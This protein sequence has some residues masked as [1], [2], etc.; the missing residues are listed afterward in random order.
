MSI[1]RVKDEERNMALTQHLQVAGR[2]DVG[3]KRPIN[4]DT[5]RTQIPNTNARSTHALFV[6]ADGVGGNLPRG[7]AASRAAVDT[8]IDSF[9]QQSDTTTPLS[10]VE[11]AVQVA[12]LAVQ[13]QAALEGVDRIGTTLAGLSLTP[14]GMA[15]VFNVGDSRVYRIRDEKIELLSHD[16]ITRS[17]PGVVAD[18]FQQKRSTRISSY[19]GQPDTLQPIFSRREVRLND[20]YIICTDG[21]WSKVSDDELKSILITEGTVDDAADRI[22]HL[23]HERG[24]PDNLTLVITHIGERLIAPVRRSLLPLLLLCVLLALL[25]AGGVYAAQNGVFA[26]PAP[27]EVAVILPTVTQTDT[28]EPISTDTA[29]PPTRTR[30]ASSTPSLTVTPSLTTMPPTATATALP[31]TLTSTPTDLPSSTPTVIPTAVVPTVTLDQTAF[32]NTPT[33]SAT[34]VSQ[35]ATITGAV[36]LPALDDPMSLP[37][38]LQIYSAITF[39]HEG[40]AESETLSPG[41]EFVVKANRVLEDR[42]VWS[43]IEFIDGTG[44]VQTRWA[45]IPLT[46]YLLVTADR[47][48]NVRTGPGTNYDI[49]Y[50]LVTGTRV[51]IVGRADGERGVWYVVRP[52]GRPTGYVASWVGGMEAGG[53][54]DS[55][56]LY[57]VPP[58]PT[59]TSTP[60]STPDEDANP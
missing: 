56:P 38:V 34:G 27:T 26:S 3:L 47:G 14:E 54:L 24:A 33:A 53:N 23:V 4:Q 17:K 1:S 25:G 48:V 8:L 10:R 28:I 45:I 18:E 9:Y 32:P 36:A 11:E 2:T 50:T 29:L 5:F 6:V 16:Q 52:E 22:V 51:E 57:A 44:V 31:P 40:S 21:V 39:E 41:T 49:R 58:T 20:I 46:P 15:I 55:V 30:E 42:M 35:T 60:T 7:E 19:L 12:H 37:T 43:E 59:S 13:R